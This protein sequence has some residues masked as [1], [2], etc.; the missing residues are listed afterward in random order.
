MTVAVLAASQGHNGLGAVPSHSPSIAVTTALP[1]PGPVPSPIVTPRGMPS[2]GMAPVARTGAAYCP[3]VP[4]LPV[5]PD[6]SILTS[7]VKTVTANESIVRQIEGHLVDLGN[8]RSRA[9]A[10]NRISDDELAYGLPILDN[11]IDKVSELAVTVTHVQSCFSGSDGMFSVRAER[12]WNEAHRRRGNLVMFPTM[13]DEQT[14]Y[15]GD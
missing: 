3:P 14:S 15:S 11:L 4:N 8:W 7:E 10:D 12:G 6:V 2:D 13:Q 1:I 5:R 9:L